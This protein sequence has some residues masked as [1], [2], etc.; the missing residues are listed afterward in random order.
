[1]WVYFPGNTARWQVSI[2]LDNA[3]PVTGGVFEFRMAGDWVTL[4][5]DP[6][7][8]YRETYYNDDWLTAKGFDIA[9]YTAQIDRFLDTGEWLPVP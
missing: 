6:G 9:P 3:L 2:N 7:E 8:R 5:C 1:M 4:L